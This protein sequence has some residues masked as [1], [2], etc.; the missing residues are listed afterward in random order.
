METPTH[1]TNERCT[2]LRL[3]LADGLD[4]YVCAIST[5]R[6]RASPLAYYDQ[7]NFHN[8]ASVRSRFQVL[9]NTHIGC[10]NIISQYNPSRWKGMLTYKSSGEGVHLP[11]NQIIDSE[12]Y[13]G[14]NNF[15]GAPPR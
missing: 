1:E 5:D 10:V 6:S 8:I 11:L 3:Y 13:D 14:S 12:Q 2:W 7:Q 9:V 4:S 15:L